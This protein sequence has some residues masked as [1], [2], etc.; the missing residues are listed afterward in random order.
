VEVH[1]VWRDADRWTA[2]VRFRDGV[3]GLVEAGEFRTIDPFAVTELTETDDTFE[4]ILSETL[5]GWVPFDTP[6]RVVVDHDAGHDW[7]LDR[8][9]IESRRVL[10]S[11]R[12]RSAV[13]VGGVAQ[14]G[15]LLLRM[16]AAATLVEPD[17]LSGLQADLARRVLDN[18]R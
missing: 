18:Y 9:D 2:L 12:I 14:L 16:G 5:S 10:D 6:V 8:L 7:M 17:E 11:G 4:P 3:A 15:V 1:D 13:T